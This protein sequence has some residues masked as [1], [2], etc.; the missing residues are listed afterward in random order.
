MK[1]IVMAV[2]LALGLIAP[3]IA[4]TVSNGPYYATPSWDQTL[5]TAQRFIVLANM[6]SQAVLDRETG[7]VWERAATSALTAWDIARIQ[8]AV[9]TTGGKMGWRVPSLAEL[10]SLVDPTATAP[11]LPPGHPFTDVSGIV[12]PNSFYWTATTDAADPT[13]VWFVGLSRGALPGAAVG[14][15]TKAVATLP[16]WCVRG[17][18]N[19]DAY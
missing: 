17:G 18:M 9:R 16:F 11:A 1:R 4:Q 6:N 12:G 8:C 15:A 3:G 7:L 2:V 13:Q 5:P 10:L 19:A 14:R